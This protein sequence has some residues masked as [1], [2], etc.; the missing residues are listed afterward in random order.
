[1]YFFKLKQK[2]YLGFEN[3][4]LKAEK[5]HENVI[6]MRIG[7]RTVRQIN[8]TIIYKS[9]QQYLKIYYIKIVSNYGIILYVNPLNITKTYTLN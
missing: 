6:L 1:M 7:K 4:L 8:K 5:N 2:R 3:R 9:R